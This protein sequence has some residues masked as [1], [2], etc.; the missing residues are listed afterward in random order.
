M[1]YGYC[2]AELKHRHCG[3]RPNLQHPATLVR[4]RQRNEDMQLWLASVR[5]AEPHFW[6]S[7]ADLP[8]YDNEAM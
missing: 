5:N 1:R 8:S 2:Q 4:K 7:S 6:F 3:T